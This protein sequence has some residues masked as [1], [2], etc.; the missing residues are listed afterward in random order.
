MPII[1]DLSLSASAFTTTWRASGEIPER[2]VAGGTTAIDANGN[3]YIV[4]EYSNQYWAGSAT[5]DSAQGGRKPYQR[6]NFIAKLVTKLK[7]GQ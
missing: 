3:P 1:S 7:Y 6:F 4:P 2:A 5:I